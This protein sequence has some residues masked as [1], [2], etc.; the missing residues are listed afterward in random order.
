MLFDPFENV[1][2]TL[3]PSTSRTAANAEARHVRK[4]SRCC[5]SSFC[6]PIATGAT[7]QRL[8]QPAAAESVCV[9]ERFGDGVDTGRME[10]SY[11]PIR[12]V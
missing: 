8:T 7:G 4:I 9:R 11:V 2:E 3:A 1:S 6:V 12:R 10:E 5:H